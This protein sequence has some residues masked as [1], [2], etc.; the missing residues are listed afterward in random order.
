MFTVPFQ[1]QPDDP[2]N[3]LSV[4]STNECVPRCERHAWG[5]CQKHVLQLASVSLS[6]RHSDRD[7][8][9]R[10]GNRYD[11]EVSANPSSGGEIEAGNTVENS[12]QL[13]GN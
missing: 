5:L 11:S 1:C 13:V 10:S 9:C 3:R 2:L 8:L 7:K 4:D 6:L 12:V